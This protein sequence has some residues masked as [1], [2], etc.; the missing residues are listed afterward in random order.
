M[1]VAML[2]ESTLNTLAATGAVF[3]AGLLLVAMVAALA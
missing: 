3:I 1:N 2:Y